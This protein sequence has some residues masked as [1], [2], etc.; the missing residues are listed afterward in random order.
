MTAK[1]LMLN[2]EILP[3]A[4]PCLSHLNRGFLYADVFSFDLR[5]NSSKA[6]FADRYFD[7]LIATM[8][9]LK[10]E[11]PLL[12]KKS[13]FETDLELLLQKNRIYKGFT[14]RVSVF[15]DDSPSLLP[16]KNSVS[17]LITVN[18]FPQEEYKVLNNGLK[19]N[20]LRNYTIPDFVFKSDITPYFN[21]EL[22]LS[23][24]LEEFD[25]DD[26]F[27]TDSKS[28]VVKTIFSSV[29][30]IKDNKLF[31]PERIPNDSKKVFT[32]LVIDAAR[33]L[34]ILVLPKSIKKEDLSSA[35]E[36]F[37]VDVINGI[38]WVLAYGERRYYHRISTLLINKINEMI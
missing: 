9:R 7:Y 17:I 32:E 13:I 36:I 35:D 12:L 14:A 2:G 28:N 1:Y 30:I 25:I 33:S 16:E 24:Y 8:S 27:I 38:R 18:E 10:M 11:R 26:V 19:L 21:E 6:F 29:F 37:C 34:K 4:K 22:L 15:R 23:S 5:G 31:V 3:A 20:I